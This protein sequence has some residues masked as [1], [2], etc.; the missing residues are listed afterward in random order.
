M[1]IRFFGGQGSV[2]ATEGGLPFLEEEEI[3]PTILDIAQT[4]H[5][6]SIRG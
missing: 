4:S 3:I 1:R 2:G 6:P 5:V